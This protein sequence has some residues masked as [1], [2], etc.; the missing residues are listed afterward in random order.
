[1]IPKGLFT[2]I[3]MVIMSVGIIFTYVKPSLSATA[4][5]QE[6]IVRYQEELEGVVSVNSRLSGLVSEMESVSNEDMRRLVTYMPDAIDEISVSRD[7]LL[8]TKEAGV[9][10]KDVAYHEGRDSN[11]STKNKAAVSEDFPTPYAFQLSIQGTYAQVKNF[12]SLLERNN[13]PIE[14][15]EISVGA[16]EG[17]FLNADMQLVTYGYKDRFSSNQVSN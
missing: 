13:Y 11:R 16:V 14:V 15:H 7:L 4:N 5:V 17:G 6:D 12:F 1:M 10:F 9:L 2:Q 3:V 8:I